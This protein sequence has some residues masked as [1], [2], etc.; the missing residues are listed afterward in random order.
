MGLEN[1]NIRA[2]F[3][4]PGMIEHKK[5][6]Y[7]KYLLDIMRGKHKFVYKEPHLQF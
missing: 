7:F 2:D 3:N 5:N 4:P 1:F 6:G